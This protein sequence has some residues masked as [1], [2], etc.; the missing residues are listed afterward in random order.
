MS[1]P[2][3]NRFST[4]RL[5]PTVPG[6]AT[7]VAVAE[8]D[9]GAGPRPALLQTPGAQAETENSAPATEGAEPEAPATW[10]DE[11]EES[12]FRAEARDRG[13]TVKA[14]AAAAE[15]AEDTVDPKSLPPLETLV[16]RLSPEVRDTLED[17]FRAKFVRVQR[18]P[19][20]VLKS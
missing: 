2:R 9:A 14:S 5:A 4:A 6:A 12:A 20:R 13:E 10:P 8:P 19:K 3:E 16:N 17:L 7:A 15:L 1:P 11:A 18:V